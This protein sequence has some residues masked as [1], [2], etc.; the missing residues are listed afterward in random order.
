VGEMWNTLLLGWN[1]IL[2]HDNKQLEYPFEKKYS[3]CKYSFMLIYVNYFLLMP[4]FNHV[5]CCN[6]CSIQKC[7]KPGWNIDDDAEEK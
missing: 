1:F 3:I 7:F 5:M 6:T 4:C 2:E